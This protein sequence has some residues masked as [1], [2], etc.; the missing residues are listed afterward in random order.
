MRPSQCIN[1]PKKLSETRLRPFV[2]LAWTQFT[3][4]I[5]VLLADICGEIVQKEKRKRSF[6]CASRSGAT[7]H[8]VGRA[9]ERS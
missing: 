8:G 6:S 9:L 5:K 2:F 7:K 1:V 3:L 4:P